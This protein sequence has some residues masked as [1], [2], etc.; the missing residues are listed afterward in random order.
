MDGEERLREALAE[1]AAD[2]SPHADI[3]LVLLAAKNDGVAWREAWARATR[4]AQAPPTLSTAAAA[5]VAEDRAIVREL[6]PA[7]RAAYE[8]RPLTAV[9]IAQRERLAERRLSDLAA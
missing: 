6:K 3:L 2:G 1:L 7:L 8:D 9:E 4:T 5:V